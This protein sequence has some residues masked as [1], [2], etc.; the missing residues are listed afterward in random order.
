[1]FPGRCQN[2]I[3]TTGW[4]QDEHIWL[5]F[6][7][8][9]EL[10]LYVLEMRIF[11]Q[12]IFSK[13]KKK[14]KKDFHNPLNFYLFWARNALS[15]CSAVFPLFLMTS[16]A[17]RDRASMST[18]STAEIKCEKTYR[19]GDVTALSRNFARRLCT[20]TASHDSDVSASSRHQTRLLIRRLFLFFKY[21]LS[22]TTKWVAY[23]CVLFVGNG[24]DVIVAGGF[25]MNCILCNNCWFWQDEPNKYQQQVQD[26]IHWF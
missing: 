24:G 19:R 17:R 9:K 3:F 25:F 21:S 1:M 20:V 5:Y 13:K 11:Q 8:F 23:T 16:V 15:N 10:E 2:V 7:F 12:Q 22:A 4:H 6:I 26:F 14:M 18:G